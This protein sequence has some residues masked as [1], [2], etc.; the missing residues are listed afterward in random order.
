MIN[1][2]AGNMGGKV[3]F[4]FFALGVPLC[5]AFWFL[6]PETKG[7]TFEEVCLSPLPCVCA[8]R[9]GANVFLDGSAFWCK[10]ATSPL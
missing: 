9:A 4:V 2:D 6:I 8:K 5:A 7:F 10:G 1:P 3:G